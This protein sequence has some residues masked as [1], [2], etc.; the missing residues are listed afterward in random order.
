M[1]KGQLGGILGGL[2]AVT[3]G[4]SIP[5]CGSKHPDASRRKTSDSTAFVTFAVRF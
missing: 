5:P 1:L 3:F 2:R 4:G